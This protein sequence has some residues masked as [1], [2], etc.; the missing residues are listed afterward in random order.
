MPYAPAWSRFPA[1]WAAE[2]EL[3]LPANGE[4]ES[5]AMA[6]GAAAWTPIRDLTGSSEQSETG[7]G[8]DTQEKAARVIWSL[9]PCALDSA[10][11][12]M[13]V[14]VREVGALTKRRKKA[15]AN[16]SLPS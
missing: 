2:F 11:V 16:R 7:A 14:T 5:S 15:L 4:P 6:V 12:T 13:A 9:D 10:V 1:V 8:G 3:G